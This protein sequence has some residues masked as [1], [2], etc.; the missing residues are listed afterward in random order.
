[1]ERNNKKIKVIKNLV[2]PKFFVPMY[3]FISSSFFPWYF[4]QSVINNDDPNEKHFQFVHTFIKHDEFNN[5]I[6][7]TPEK[8]LD[9]VRPVLSALNV[10]EVLRCKLN[11]TTRTP[12]PVTHGL[13]VDGIEGATHTAVFY[14]NTNNGGTVFENGKKYPSIA[15]QAVVFDPKL[16]H[17][18]VSCTD[19][20][21][22]LVLNINY[23]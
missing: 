13:H 1:M 8:H 22:R 15:N 17:S 14:L 3:E 10:N 21:I 11:L 19:E 2:K 20:K 4:N 7:N 18:G 23:K 9:I 16:L 5:A 12:E 6:V